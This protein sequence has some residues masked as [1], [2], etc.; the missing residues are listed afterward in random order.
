M[1]SILLATARDDVRQEVLGA[2]GRDALPVRPVATWT[3]L[4]GSL[5][6][7]EAR[8]ALVDAELPGLNAALLAELSR[9]LAHR[10]SVR[11][12][13][14]VQPPLPRVQ[15]GDRALLRV[16]RAALPGA[17]LDPVERRALAWIGIGA[18][19][20]ARLTG[21]AA[22]RSPV[23]VQGERGTGKER[24]A[25]LVH[26]LARRAGAFVERR[27]GARWEPEGAPGTLYLSAAHEH[28]DVRDVVA[29]AAAHGWS[30][31]A[32]TRTPDAALAVSWV[33]LAVVPLRERPDD[34]RALAT[35]ALD[36]HARRLGLPRRSFDRA[37][38]ALIF[39]HR[40]PGNA[41]EL[42]DFVIAALAASDG[43][44]IR[45]AALPPEVQVLLQPRTGT[46]DQVESFEEMARARLAPVVR[47]YDPGPGVSLRD[48]VVDAAERA[49]FALA[50]A[51]T[52]GNRKQAAALLGVA[53]NTLQTRV[54]RLGITA[55]RG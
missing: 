41:R 50:L 5:C 55:T 28:A 12:I 37:A 14:G 22:T 21:L 29:R 25:R 40:W 7:P 26:R 9:S 15:P 43:P 31:I 18:D 46:A 53:R 4:C 13:R 23:L 38:W 17:A 3:D 44:V 48:I 19:P 33:R 51:R 16:V 20:L 35:A 24:I 49:L 47:A 32:G 2:L 1:S 52:G 6:A 34:L 30:V 11:V 10:P 27:P 39:A 45:G 36:T 54:E 8:L 42:E